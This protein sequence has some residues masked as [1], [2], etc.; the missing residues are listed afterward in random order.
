MVEIVKQNFKE[1]KKIFCEMERILKNELEKSVVISHVGSTAIP[2][3]Y[4]KNIID[5]LVGVEN[6]KIF[7]DVS[8]KLKELGYYPSDKSKTIEYQF[9]ASKKEETKSGD[10]H[11]H[12][13]IINTNR[14][15]EFL[16]LRDYLL[17]NPNVAKEYSDYKK[18]ILKLESAERSQYR[19]I[20][21]IYVSNLIE[22]A[23]NR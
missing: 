1:N 3:I 17:D 22:R 20:K 15:N 8:S 13:G 9:F 14:Y 18:K 16:L 19:N 4:G 11:I 10:I 6:T 12:L 21:S 5:I 7:K 2:K 23:K